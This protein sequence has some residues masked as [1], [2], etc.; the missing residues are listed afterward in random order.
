MWM[1]AQLPMFG[2]TTCEAMPS[3]TSSPASASGPTPRGA[4]DG[5]T[6]GLCGPGAARAPASAR[7]AKAAGLTTLVTSG[8]NGF[9]S[10]ASV[11]LEQCLA[12]RLQQRL[13][14]AGSTLFVETWKRK[15]TPL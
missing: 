5:P 10:S 3:A 4:Q 15:A 9:A 7:Q 14:T 11:A 12:S 8:R 13:D 2:P 6:A 1:N